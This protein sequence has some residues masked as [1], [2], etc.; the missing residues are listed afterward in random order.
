MQ[1]SLKTTKGHDHIS[2]EGCDI[3]SESPILGSPPHPSFESF[4]IAGGAGL[5]ASTLE[6][7]SDALPS[8]RS[9]SAL[10]LLLLAVAV[11]PANVFMVTHNAPGPGPVGQVILSMGYEILGHLIRNC[12][13]R[14]PM[15]KF[16]FV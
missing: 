14:Q 13:Q 10:G 4:Q 6:P 9:A 3:I 2:N 5:L 16:R 11:T 8:L 15:A 1:F 7:V 12:F